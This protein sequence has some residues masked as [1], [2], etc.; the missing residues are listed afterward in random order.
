M[1]AEL[2]PTAGMKAAL[3]QAAGVDFEAPEEAP[4]DPFAASFAS[5]Q[6]STTHNNHNTLTTPPPSEPQ[7]QQQQQQQEQQQPSLFPAAP[8]EDPK[9]DPSSLPIPQHTEATPEGAQG[10]V[11]LRDSKNNITSELVQ[12]TVHEVC[13]DAHGDASHRGASNSVTPVDTEETVLAA[14]GISP[15]L[16]GGDESTPRGS[17]ARSAAAQRARSTSETAGDLHG[18]HALRGG[19]GGARRGVIYWIRQDFRLQDNPALC[20]AAELA[21]KHG[22]RVY[23]VYIHSPGEI[24]RHC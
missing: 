6:P 5:P 15:E 16:W 7:V 24:C 17:T 22:G 2:A 23:C 8:S 9:V 3:L 11:T 12:Q 18:E 14:L 1:H 19:T 13:D 21:R 10:M 20:C 4:L